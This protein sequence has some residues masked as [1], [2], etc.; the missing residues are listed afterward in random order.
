MLRWQPIPPLQMLITLTTDFG[1]HDAFVGIMKGVIFAINP[2][3]Q[4]I[5][6][7]HGIPA[8][9]IVAGAL[10]LRHAIGYFPRGTIHVAVVD[11][12]VGTP[13]RP[14]LIESDGSYFI[15]PDN[16]IFSL[17]L[18][19]KTPIR[20]IEISNPTYRL[21]SSSATFHGRDIFA[22]A[23]AHLSLGAEPHS[24]GTAVESMVELALPKLTRS[25][26]QIDGEIMYIDGYGN[27]FT[28]VNE[29]DLTGLPIDR[30]ITQCGSL[31]I[32][33]VVPSYGSTHESRYVAVIN[34]WGMLEVALCNGSARAVTGLKV[35]DKVTLTWDK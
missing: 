22:P 1:Y 20:I 26:R 6:L 27:L 16:G 18:A 23:A 30:L 12:G 9:D 29:H 35:G 13:R 24:F 32:M 11:P 15:G 2:Q 33:G 31:R 7:S 4:V 28:N 10:T 25:E 21:G 34:S 17:T 3:A 19:G 8:Q 5:D 14:L